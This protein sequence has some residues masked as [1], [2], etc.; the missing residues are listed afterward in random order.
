MRYVVLPLLALVV[1][2]AQSIATENKPNIVLIYV[3]DLGYGDLGCYGSE[4]NDTPH[5]D[6]LAADGMRFTDYYSASPV[7]TPSRAALLTGGYPGRVSF[8]VFNGS[9]KSW[10]LFPGFAEGLHPNELLLPEYLKWQGYA[11]SHVGK[12]HLGDQVEHLPTR[13]GFDSYYGIPYSN[14]MAIMP[15]KKKSPPLPLL[16]DEEVIAEQPKQAPLIQSYTEEAVSFIRENQDQPFFLYF[17]HMHVHLPHYVMDPFLEASRNGVY[18]AAVAAVDWST[19]VIVAEIERL[20]L[21]ENTI[22][23]YTSDNGSRVDSHGGS[24]GSLR[25]TKGQ[26]WEGGMRVPCI[27]KWPGQIEPGSVSTELVTAMDFYPTFASILEQPLA[28]DPVRDGHDVSGIWKGEP[29]ARSPH[30]AFFYYLVDQLQAVRVGDWKLRYAIED[31]R[32]A[33]R[34]QLELYNLAKDLSEQ[35]NVASQHPKIVKDLIQQMEAMGD[36]IGDGLR[37]T[38]G[39]ERRPHS[40]S[41]DPKP[42]TEFDEDY[43]YIEP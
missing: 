10:V 1:L 21:D 28:N 8:D 29:G 26:T 30:D 33:D 16:R 18:G 2:L 7:C 37:D 9:R 35:N 41:K 14:D 12:W 4:K 19:G 40:I 11:T 22:V 5:V 23:I 17:A 27:V 39:D 20:G 42:L 24:N 3:D 36:R 25:G 15:R 38:L 13:H 34:S 32:N 31:R 6:Q 43:P